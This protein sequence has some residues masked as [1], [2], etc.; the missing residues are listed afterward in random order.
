DD[1]VVASPPEAL[2]G[3]VATETMISAAPNHVAGLGE[4][5]RA[6]NAAT[7]GRGVVLRWPARRVEQ[8]A[9]TEAAASANVSLTRA[10][11]DETTACPVAIVGMGCVVPG[12]RDIPQY[13]QNII[14]GVSG[15]VE[16]QKII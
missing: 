7:H 14:E 8:P 11:V 5:A 9:R 4:I 6:V 12:A 15:V 2:N 10:G 13:W 3:T 1:T 16:M